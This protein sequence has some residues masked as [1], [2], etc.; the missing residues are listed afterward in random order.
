MDKFKD[1]ILSPEE[2]KGE[3]IEQ[4]KNSEKIEKQENLMNTE[5]KLKSNFEL[6]KELDLFFPHELVGSGLAL[7]TPKGATIKRELERFIVDE[8][9][10]RGYQFTATPVMSKTDLYKISGHL[11]HYKESMFF[12]KTADEEFALRPMTCPFQFLIYKNKIRSYKD[13]P[14]KYAEIST[15]FRNEKSGEL[16]GITRLRQ[17][18]LSDGH[19]I[20]RPDQFEE[21]FK[22]TLDLINYTRKTLKL[23]DLWYRFSKW[24]PKNKEKYI[25]DPKAWEKSQASMKKILD[26]LNL[27]YIEAEDE[28]A[29][30]GPKL[31]IQGKYVSG[32]EDTLL[33]VQVDFALPEKFDLNYIDEKG[34][35]R[36]PIVIHRSSIGC[37]ERMMGYLLEKTQGNLPTWLSPIQV[38]VISFANK[39]I[40]KTE[41]ITRKFQENG[42]RVEADLKDATVNYKVRE[43]ELEKIPYIIV[44][45][46]KEEKTNTIAVRKKGERPSFGI[47]IEEFIENLIKEIRERK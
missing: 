10:K 39:N 7:L 23:D 21:E 30:Y 2:K 28:A 20:C 41:E 45:G 9:I 17:F 43:A 33:T 29:F 26:E 18:S 11:D 36:R 8:E 19:I 14:L 35:P 12:I 44:I 6:G 38:K 4:H 13:L 25:D 37:L 5:K 32:K 40:E 31:D 27:K 47:K 46:D 1:K 42:M 16:M 22:G 15:L 24:D 34:E 3:Q